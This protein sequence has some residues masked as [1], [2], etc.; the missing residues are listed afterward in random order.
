MKTENIVFEHIE[1]LNGNVLLAGEKVLVLSERHD[2][3]FYCDVYRN[4]KGLLCIKIDGEEQSIRY[5]LDNVWD[6]EIVIPLFEYIF[7]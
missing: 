2:K 3:P 5:M 1:D 6:M 4:P 7:E